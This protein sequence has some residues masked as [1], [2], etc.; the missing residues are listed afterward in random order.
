DGR[1][2]AGLRVRARDARAGP[3]RGAARMSTAP[4]RAPVGYPATPGPW[5]PYMPYPIDSFQVL[6]ALRL[7]WAMSELRGRLRPGS[8]LIQVTPQS[9]PLRA[10]HALPLGGERTVVEQLIEAE[11]VVSTLAQRLGLGVDVDQLTG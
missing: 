1:G 4:V 10:D 11:A 6:S 2:K 9:G 7:G 8:K 5:P 3:P